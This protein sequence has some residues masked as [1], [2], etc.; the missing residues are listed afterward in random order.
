MCRGA[1]PFSAGLALRWP[2][3]G[4]SPAWLK[5]SL[6]HVQGIARGEQDEDIILT[7]KDQ[8]VLVLDAL[9]QVRTVAS[10]RASS[11]EAHAEF[12]RC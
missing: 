12:P 10:Q 5:H 8:G 9:T 4:R 7:S 2:M 6:K 1:P 3:G 11:K